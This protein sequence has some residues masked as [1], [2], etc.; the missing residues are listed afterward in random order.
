MSGRSWSIWFTNI[1]I[2]ESLIVWYMSVHAWSNI[3][4]LTNIFHPTYISYCHIH[5]S[6]HIAICTLVATMECSTVAG[7]GKGV[8]WTKG[9]AELALIALAWFTLYDFFLMLLKF[10]L[11][12]LLRKVYW[13]GNETKWWRE[14]TMLMRTVASRIDKYVFNMSLMSGR[15][16]W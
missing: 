13:L 1:S 12:Q 2:K 3:V 6:L 16:E 9:G 8:G 15:P 11:T 10:G 7:A 14:N 4:C 5:C